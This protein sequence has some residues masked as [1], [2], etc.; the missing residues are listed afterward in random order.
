MQVLEKL[1]RKERRLC[2]ESNARQGG[3]LLITLSKLIGIIRF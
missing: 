3:V 1:C 2:L